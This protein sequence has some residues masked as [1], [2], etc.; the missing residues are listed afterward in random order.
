ML[1]IEESK[2]LRL[3][4]WARFRNYSAV[5][6]K[7]KGKP[8]LW[9][10]NHTKISQLK[11][12]FEFETNKAIVGIDIETRNLDKRIELFGKLEQFKTILETTMGTEMMW[13]LEYT[14]TNG[15]SISRIYV[16]KTGVS[17][18]NKEDWPE[19]FTFLYKNMMKLEKFYEEYWEGI[20]E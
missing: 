19:V 1:T 8:S 3:D 20:K 12:K 9:I 2:Q 5:R 6:R 18:Y 10:M 14:L 16:E 7:Q 15:K 13:E 4:F 11:L 17:I